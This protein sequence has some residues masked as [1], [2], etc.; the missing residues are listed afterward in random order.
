MLSL[1]APAPIA[2]ADFAMNRR[3]R[4]AAGKSKKPGLGSDQ[5]SSA[6]AY[7]AVFQH[8]RLPRSSLFHV[9]EHRLPIPQ[10]KTFLH[11]NGLRFVGFNVE[12]RIVDNFRNRF[13]EAG[14]ATD[15]ERW[16]VFEIDHPIVFST[17]YN[18]WIQKPG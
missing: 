12:S 8:E 2:T 14:A 9:Q 17:M 15:L 5:P 13:P 1:E 10:I 7:F 16:H 4:R 11:D 18:F 3:E 6:E